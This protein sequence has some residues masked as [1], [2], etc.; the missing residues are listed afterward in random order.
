M[1]TLPVSLPVDLGGTAKLVLNNARA[2]ATLTITTVGGTVICVPLA[3]CA[4]I[5]ITAGSDA[6]EPATS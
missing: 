5:S 1:Q 2:N 4:E 3:N 6:G